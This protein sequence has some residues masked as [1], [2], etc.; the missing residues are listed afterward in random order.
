MKSEI[1]THKEAAK[2]LEIV[3]NELDEEDQQPYK[4]IAELDKIRY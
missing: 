1:I 4:K 2:K 3:W